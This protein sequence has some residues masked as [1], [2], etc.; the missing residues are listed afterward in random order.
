L[1]KLQSETKE[2]IKEEIYE[3]KKTAEDVKQKI[4]KDVENL[5][6]KNQTEIL[7]IK[8]SLNEIKNTMEIQ[9]VRLEEVEDRKSGFEDKIHT[10]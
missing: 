8:S 10:K 6:K 4:N 3:I 1:Y 7:E 2:A 5:R 9:S